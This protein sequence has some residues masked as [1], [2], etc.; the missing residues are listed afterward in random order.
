V[1]HAS[2]YGEKITSPVQGQT[3][4]YYFTSQPKYLGARYQVITKSCY[5]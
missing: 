5:T 3:I 2:K 4:Q 1:R